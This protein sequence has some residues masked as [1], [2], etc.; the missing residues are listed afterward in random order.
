MSFV[1][2]CSVVC[3][4]LLL[5]LDAPSAMSGLEAVQDLQVVRDDVII[6]RICGS[7]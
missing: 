2:C 4:A 1:A 3:E 7:L 5:Y 6:Y